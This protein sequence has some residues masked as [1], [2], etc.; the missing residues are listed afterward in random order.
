MALLNQLVDG[1]LSPSLSIRLILLNRDQERNPIAL[2][3]HSLDLLPLGFAWL[4][5]TYRIG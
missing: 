5:P 1:S 3:I 4:N 2:V